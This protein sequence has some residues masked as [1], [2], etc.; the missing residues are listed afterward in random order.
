MSVTEDDSKQGSAELHRYHLKRPAP[1]RAPRQRV[2]GGGRIG[3][4]PSPG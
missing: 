1:M 3:Q 2:R 4:R